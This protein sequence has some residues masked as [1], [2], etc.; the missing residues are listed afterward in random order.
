MMPAAQGRR[1]ADGGLLR[2]MEPRREQAQHFQRI[3]YDDLDSLV[4]TQ[5]PSLNGFAGGAA[6]VHDDAYFRR[7]AAQALVKSGEEIVVISAIAHHERGGL[8]RE[9]AK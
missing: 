2:R 7:T 3:G 1:F 6:G 4:P 5:V 8:G 9:L